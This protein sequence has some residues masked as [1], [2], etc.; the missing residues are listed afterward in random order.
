V[1]EQRHHILTFAVTLLHVG[2]A[3]ATIAIVTGG[4]RWPWLTSIALGLGGTAAAVY[5]YLPMAGN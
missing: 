4:K 5:A 2:I 1:H 3:M